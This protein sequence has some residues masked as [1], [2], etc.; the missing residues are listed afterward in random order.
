MKT[1]FYHL[2]QCEDLEV[3]QQEVLCASS[4]SGAETEYFYEF[5]NLEMN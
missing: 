3:D 5:G 1:K 4:E 2:P